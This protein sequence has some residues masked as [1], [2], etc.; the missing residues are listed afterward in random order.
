MGSMMS[1]ATAGG[2]AAAAVGALVV[3]GICCVAVPLIRRILHPE[4]IHFPW[5][6]EV[7]VDTT[8]TNN[9]NNNNHHKSNDDPNKTKTKSNT[10]SRSSSIITKEDRIVILAGS[11]NPPHRGHLEMLNYLSRRYVRNFFRV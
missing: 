11:Y 1:S 3:G 6:D 10:R 7:D 2:A 4:I 5:D 8:T 9:N